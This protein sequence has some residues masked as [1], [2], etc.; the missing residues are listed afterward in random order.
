MLGGSD[1]TTILANSS[2]PW[3]KNP[4]QPNHLDM[5]LYLRPRSHPSQRPPSPRQAPHVRRMPPQPCQE[6]PGPET[7]VSI[8][9]L[10]AFPITVP[11]RHPDEKWTADSP[12]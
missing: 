9:I 11:A 8:L 6:T 7:S 5:P 4:P 12:S 2:P 10:I 1:A 3:P